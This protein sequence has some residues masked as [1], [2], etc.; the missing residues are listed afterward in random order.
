[1]NRVGLS[2]NDI[3]LEVIIDNNIGWNAIAF[4]S[5]DSIPCNH[6]LPE[7]KLFAQALKK[8]VFCGVLDV[9]ENPTITQR[10]AVTAVP[11][12]LLFRD[13]KELARYEGPYAYEAILERAR[14]VMASKK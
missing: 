10:C 5:R 7:F 6:F 14:R 1:M 2:I 9:D 13:G 3:Q 11:T 4:I 12:T 8:T